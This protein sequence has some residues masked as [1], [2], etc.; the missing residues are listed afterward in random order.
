MKIVIVSQYFYPEDF[1]INDLAEEFVKRGHEV[2]VLTGKPNY[3]FGKFFQGYRF[4][5][6]V[7]EVYRGATIIRVPLFPRGKGGSIR[8]ILN[9]LSYIIFGCWYVA[10]HRITADAAI[11]FG[12][13]PITQIYPA[14]LLKKKTGCSVSLWVQDLWPESVSATTGIK[15]GFLYRCL[16]GMVSRIYRKCD[17]LLVQSRD[18][19][20]SILE[21]GAFG[22]KIVYAPNWAEDFYLNQSQVDT[23]KYADLIADGFIIMFAG[24]IGVAQDLERVIDAAELTAHVPEIKWM[25]VGDGRKRQD[26]ETKVKSK[27]LEKSVIFLG[28]YSAIEMPAFFIHADVMLVSLKDNPI[29]TLTI[30]SK[31][32]TYMASGKPILSMVGGITG[33]IIKEAACGLDADASDVHTLADNAIALSRMPKVELEKMGQRA[34]SYYQRYFAKH[35]VIDVIIDSLCK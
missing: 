7:K 19:A 21:K 30:P 4:W 9:Y 3:P 35:K 11:C 22:S 13:S 5:G 17:K 6:T 27:G 32:Q 26:V 2:T 1:K 25:I 15:R 31:I 33:K 20:Q 8:L 34:K 10:T 23:A 14:L 28:R 16:H 18:F 24:N 12:T 29:F